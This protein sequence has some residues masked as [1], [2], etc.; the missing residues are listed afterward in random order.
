MSN[1]RREQFGNSAPSPVKRYYQWGSE[2]KGFKWYDKEAKENKVEFPLSVAF[3][4]SR[5][6]VRGWHDLTES[7]I[8]ANEVKNTAQEPLSVYS[9]KPDKKGNTLLATGIYKNIKGD[10]QGGHFEKVLYAYQEGVGVV[11]INLKGSALQAFSNFEKDNKRDVL[12]D[13]LLTIKTFE[14]AKK[15]ATKYTVPN[16]ELGGAISKDLD[17]KANEAYKEVVAYLDS[18][19]KSKDIVEEEVGV[20][21]GVFDEETQSDGLPF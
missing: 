9:S 5:S 6:T 16:F 8:Y 15:G 17:V 14:S 7:S 19:G 1:D 11:K 18:K 20:P 12:F 2:V 3:I 4:T 10:L 13:N 21:E